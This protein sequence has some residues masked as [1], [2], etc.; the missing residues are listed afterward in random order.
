[1]KKLV[2]FA[3]GLALACASPAVY[4]QEKE[5]GKGKG[6]DLDRVSGRVHMINKAASEMEIRTSSSSVHRKVAWNA[7]TKFTYR[8]Q[9]GSIDNL[10]EGVRV[11][12]LGK[13]DGV[14]LMAARID[15]RDQ[16]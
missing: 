3:I 16:Q 13:Y 6:A 8:N 2:A 1:M 11:I 9:A 15:M 7:S 4:A 5:K 12:C 10:K 14:K